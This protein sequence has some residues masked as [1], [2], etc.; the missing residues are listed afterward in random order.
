MS[1]GIWLLAAVITAVFTMVTFVGFGVAGGGP[2]V[3]DH[4]GE[5]RRTDTMFGSVIEDRTSSFL[6]CDVA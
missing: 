1:G 6:P 4:A 3:S 2:T 5:L